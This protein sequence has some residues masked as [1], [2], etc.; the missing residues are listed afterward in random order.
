MKILLFYNTV[1]YLKPI[2]IWGRLLHSLPRMP[3][4]KVECPALHPDFKIVTEISKHNSTLDGQ[5]FTFLSESASL[6]THAVQNA[7]GILIQHHSG[8]S[9]G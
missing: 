1:R 2:Q 9:I 4:G 7:A 6:T 5:T 8:S 3:L